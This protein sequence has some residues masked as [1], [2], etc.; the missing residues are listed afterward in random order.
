MDKID[1]GLYWFIKKNLSQNAQIQ[2]VYKAYSF[3]P[4]KNNVQSQKK[5]MQQDFRNQA[6]L[7]SMKNFD[8]CFWVT[9]GCYDQS[10]F[11]QKESGPLGSVSIHFSGFPNICQLGRKWFSNLRGNSYTK[12]VM[13]YMKSHFTC[14]L[15]ILKCC[16]V[17]VQVIAHASTITRANQE[18][19]GAIALSKVKLHGLI[20]PMQNSKWLIQ[21]SF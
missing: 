12:L 10:L 1:I 16:G 19:G 2:S 5:L 14:G 21:N 7:G 8:I 13:L 11:L 17:D 20:S 6:K 9:F 15:S 4:L 3:Y 18:K